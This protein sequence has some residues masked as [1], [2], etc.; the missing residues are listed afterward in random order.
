[1]KTTA[2]VAPAMGKPLEFRDIELD[3][4]RP[5]EVLVQIHAT[6]ICHADLACIKGK[7]PVQF[8]NIFG[9]E[10]RIDILLCPGYVR[11]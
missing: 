1:M 2:L 11:S 5:D 10:G 4:L 9:H 7:I 8:P 3:E 6:G